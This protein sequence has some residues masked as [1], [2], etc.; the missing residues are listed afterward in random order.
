MARRKR[1][2]KRKARTMLKLGEYSSARQRRF[3]GAR[4]SGQPYRKNT[5]P[6]LRKAHATIERAYLS[7][8]KRKD[9][10]TLRALARPWEAIEDSIRGKS[11]KRN[12]SKH[13]KG[14]NRAG[15]LAWFTIKRGARAAGYVAARTASAAAKEAKAAGYR[16]GN[17]V[18]GEFCRNPP[19]GATLSERA[20]SITYQHAADGDWY[21]HKFGRGVVIKVAPDRKSVKLYRPDGKPLAAQFDVP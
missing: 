7:A 2:S 5:P 19:K 13:P 8:L 6:A 17:E 1:L 15:R 12:P 11:R 4:A 18:R 14:S 21:R 20:E 3:L 16:L 10:K 9:S